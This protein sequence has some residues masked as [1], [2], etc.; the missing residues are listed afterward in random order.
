LK[1]RNEILGLLGTLPQ[2]PLAEME[3][4]LL[5]IGR[6]SLAGRGIGFVDAHLLAAAFLA[7][8][9]LFTLDRRLR[10]IAS[11]LGLT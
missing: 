5:F 10:T 6:H 11:G 3:E 7:G 8:C 4:L 1:N 9:R 2:A